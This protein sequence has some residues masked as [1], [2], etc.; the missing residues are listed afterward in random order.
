LWLDLENSAYLRETLSFP[1]CQIALRVDRDVIADDGTVRFSES[2]YFLTSLDP[3]AVTADELLAAVRNHWQIENSVFFLKDRWW[4][5]D[6]HWTRRPGLSEWLAQLTTAATVVLRHFRTTDE[7][8][9]A[10]ADYIQWNP[11]LGLTLLG[12]A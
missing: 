11:L 8:L 5:E 12:R 9:R 4:D 6:R 3:S 1:G 10:L 2:R 7:P